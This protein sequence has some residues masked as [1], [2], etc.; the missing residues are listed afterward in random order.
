MAATLQAAAPGALHREKTA[1]LKIAKR[2]IF[3]RFF[4]G[5]T[6]WPASAGKFHETRITTPVEASFR[7]RVRERNLGVRETCPSCRGPSA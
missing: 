4:P 3:M 5:R 1:G 6:T 2:I 7:L